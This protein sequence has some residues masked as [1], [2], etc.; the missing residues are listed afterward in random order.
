MS[1]GCLFEV[2]RMFQGCFKEVSKVLLRCFIRAEKSAE[3]F[4]EQK[5]KGMCVPDVS[6]QLRPIF[7]QF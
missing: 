5:F 1:Q 6:D 2:L 3:E 4:R 7:F